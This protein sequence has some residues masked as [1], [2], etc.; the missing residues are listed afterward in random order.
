MSVEFTVR[1]DPPCVSGRGWDGTN[2]TWH[3]QRFVYGLLS[4][5][6][7]GGG[8]GAEISAGGGVDVNVE[9]LHGRGG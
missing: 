8:Y 7:R 4:Q 5:L 2:L 6:E 3:N 9:G 1:T